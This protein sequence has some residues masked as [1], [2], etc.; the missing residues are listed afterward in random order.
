L[1]HRITKDAMRTMLLVR[2]SIRLMAHFLIGEASQHEQFL[3]Q[4]REAVYLLN[5]SSARC[6]IHRRGSD[7]ATDKD[8]AAMPDMLA[9]RLIPLVHEH[10]NY[11][12]TLFKQLH[13]ESNIAH[14]S[15]LEEICKTK[16][17]LLSQAQTMCIQFVLNILEALHF[18][19][20]R[21]HNVLAH[22]HLLLRKLHIVMTLDSEL[23]RDLQKLM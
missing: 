11:V 15:P 19:P 3:E 13:V 12:I 5:S 21:V 23:L 10:M 16:P 8:R 17:T 14:F 2:V 4:S 9:A 18:V 1:S 6:M 20:V 7:G 22:A